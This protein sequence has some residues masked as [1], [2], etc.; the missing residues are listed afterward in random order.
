[1]PDA[2][3][4]VDDDPGRD[5]TP[6]P[7]GLLDGRPADGV[8]RVR[9]QLAGGLVGWAI[10]GAERHEAEPDGAVPDRTSG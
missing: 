4:P 7:R 2:P 9:D 1:M 5:R 3:R 10:R 8:A 6:A